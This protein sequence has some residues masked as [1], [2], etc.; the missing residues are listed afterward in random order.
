MLESGTRE[1]PEAGGRGEALLSGTRERPAT[2]PAENICSPLKQEQREGER[3]PRSL[4]AKQS[5]VWDSLVPARALLIKHTAAT[6]CALWDTERF[7][8]LWG[9]GGGAGGEHLLCEET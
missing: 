4:P 3:T 1:W 2:R 8:Q 7:Q 6:P 9:E 5:S